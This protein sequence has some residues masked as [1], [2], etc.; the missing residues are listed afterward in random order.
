[1][2]IYRF[3]IFMSKKRN[4]VKYDRKQGGKDQK[5]FRLVVFGITI[6]LLFFLWQERGLLERFSKFGYLGIFL[7]N[8][9]SS[10]SVFFPMPGVASVF[11]GGAI[12]NPIIVGLISG[13]GAS[14][15][16]VFGYLVGYGGRS[17]L[18]SIE[19]ENPWIKKIE[20]IFQK[21]GF[22]T[23]FIFSILPMPLFDI[24]GLIAGGL[25]YPIWKFT[26]AVLCGR[27]IRNIIF[28]WTG[29]KFL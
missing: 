28:A 5:L 15:G 12:W 29:A 13:L 2:R 19:K 16:E 24:I 26:M 20:R 9:I 18:G 14:L 22:L 21:M 23:I 4:S 10:A 7:V 6:L 17:L 8:F 25:N 1:M 3:K 27:V 11:V